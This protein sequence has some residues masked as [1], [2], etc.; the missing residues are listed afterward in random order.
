MFVN[1]K[2][3][4]KQTKDT[5]KPALTSCSKISGS[6]K[7]PLC[8]PCFDRKLVGL[9]PLYSGHCHF[10]FYLG[11]QFI[12]LLLFY[13]LCNRYL[14]TTTTSTKMPLNGQK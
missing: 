6:C 10:F 7:F 8:H 4:R 3:K 12:C 13:S 1:E 11:R 9:P 14:S 2:K 5:S